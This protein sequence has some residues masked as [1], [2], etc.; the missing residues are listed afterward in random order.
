[1][2][3]RIFYHPLYSPDPASAPSLPAGQVPGAVRTLGSLGYPLAE[4]A[5]PPEQIKRV[6]DAAYVEAALAGTLM[7]APFAS[8]VFPGRPC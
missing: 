8:S 7:Q 2:S 4:A 6:H 5:P 3:L 1:M